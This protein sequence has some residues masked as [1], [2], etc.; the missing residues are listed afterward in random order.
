MAEQTATAPVM[1]LSGHRYS[2]VKSP[3][4]GIACVYC[5]LCYLPECA[6]AIEGAAASAFGGD[7][8]QR[9]VHYVTVPNVTAQTP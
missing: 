4:D 8:M 3:A 2:E 7:C 1:I 9:D 6:Q 5:A